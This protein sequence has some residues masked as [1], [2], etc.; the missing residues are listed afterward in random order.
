M[1]PMTVI[2]ERIGIQYPILQAPMAGGAT[3]PELVAAVSNAGGLGSLGAGYMQPDEIKSAIVRIR[4]LTNKLFSVNLFIPENHHAPQNQ[5]NEMC[6]HIEVCC[7]ALMQYK[8]APH[9]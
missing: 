9:S 1:W 2:A 7:S 8:W 6:H 3:T 4:A 5:I